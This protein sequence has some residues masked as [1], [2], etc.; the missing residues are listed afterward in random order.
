MKYYNKLILLFIMTFILIT[1]SIGCTGSNPIIPEINPNPSTNP[2]N[3]TVSY[4][5]VS[6]SSSTIKINQSL[7]FVVKG[8]NSDDEW[9]IL[10]KSKIKLWDWS[11]LGCPTCFEGFIDLSPKSGSLTT[12]FSSGKIGTFYVVVYYQE[13]IGDAYITDYVQVKV[14]N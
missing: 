5:E 2:D 12:T 6:A 13:N 10:D 3:S 4:V 8:Y 11:A 14:T 9:V 1:M 7:Q